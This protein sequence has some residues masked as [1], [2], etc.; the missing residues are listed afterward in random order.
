MYSR[1][2]IFSE[3]IRSYV[4]KE[5]PKQQKKVEPTPSKNNNSNQ[6]LRTHFS[7]PRLETPK[8]KY[9]W[10]DSK[11]T[12]TEWPSGLSVR[13]CN[14]FAQIGAWC[15]NMTC[16]FSHNS[17]P[18]GY[19]D[20]DKKLIIKHEKNNPNFFFTKAVYAKLREDAPPVSPTSTSLKDS[21][22]KQIKKEKEMKKP[23]S[24]S[25]TNN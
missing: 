11:G 15:K 17:F 21:T 10:M 19:S 7:S 1:P 24:L 13:P 18:E 8:K 9:S 16:P 2:G 14:R 6:T 12:L 4:P 3:A 25:S 23:E 20:A 5:K 22:N